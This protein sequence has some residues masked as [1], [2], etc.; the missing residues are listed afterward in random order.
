MHIIG[1]QNNCSKETHTILETWVR[2]KFN[3]PPIW[4]SEFSTGQTRHN[5]STH[6]DCPIQIFSWFACVSTSLHTWLRLRKIKSDSVQ[7]FQK[8]PTRTRTVC[9]N[10]RIADSDSESDTFII[11]LYIHVTTYIAQTQENQVGQ[12]AKNSGN[13]QLGLGQ[14]AT[15]PE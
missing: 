12:C 10:S 11:C 6:Y 8:W 5:V 7:K 4:V 3:L 14:C 1:L 2:G 15:I 13:G 9:N